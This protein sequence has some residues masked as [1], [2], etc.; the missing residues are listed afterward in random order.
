MKELFKVFENDIMSEGFSK[1]EK[2][3]MGIITPAIFVM[4]A[5]FA[6]MLKY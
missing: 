4:V 2:I 6:S 3:I 1:V 5:I